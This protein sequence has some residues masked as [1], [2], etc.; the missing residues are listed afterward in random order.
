LQA[1]LMV[2]EKR[3]GKDPNIEVKV[4]KSQARFERVKKKGQGDK[5]VGHFFLRI[6]VLAEQADVYVPLSIASGKKVAGLM[7][8]IE[9]TDT[10][11]IEKAS[12]QAEGKGVSQ[13]TLGT[14]VFAKVPKGMVGSFEVRVTIRGSFGKKYKLVFNRLNYRLALSDARYQQYLKEIHS[15][16]VAFS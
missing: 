14:L 7:Y 9:G 16:E 5:A 4:R 12:L 13:V 11:I 10:A 2:A 8:Q 1:K 6:E 3:E 15:K